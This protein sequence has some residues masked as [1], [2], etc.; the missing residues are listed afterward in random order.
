MAE[1]LRL[2]T[3]WG[4]LGIW[5]IEESIEQLEEL[6][7]TAAPKH[8]TSQ[9][10]LREYLAWR[11]MLEQMRP[12]TSVVYNH[13]GAPTIERSYISVSHTSKYAAVLLS[14]EPCGVDI[15][16]TR[17]NFQR[18]SS[19]YI[20]DNEC[21]LNG[22]DNPLFKAI[23]WC[24]KEAMYK[25]S[26]RVELDFTCDIKINAIDFTQRTMQGYILDKAVSLSCIEMNSH[27]IAMSQWGLE[28]SSPLANKLNSQ[29]FLT[30]LKKDKGN[31]NS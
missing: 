6:S 1:W 17:R 24:A 2:D 3:D 21:N 13:L 9:N 18:I 22:S 28:G 14:S 11:A 26:G 15:E 25:L 12:S 8:I 16:S 29:T 10:R 27:I 4:E 23:I 20:S 19:R 5:S 31:I 7:K 30:P